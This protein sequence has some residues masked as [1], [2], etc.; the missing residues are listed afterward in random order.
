MLPAF[1][2]TSNFHKDY[3]LTLLLKKTTLT[4]TTSLP[5][6]TRLQHQALSEETVCLFCVC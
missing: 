5:S 1:Q 4:L 3:G 2:L 6:S